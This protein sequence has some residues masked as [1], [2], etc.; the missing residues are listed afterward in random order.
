MFEQ[1]VGQTCP[2]CKK[3]FQVLADETGSHPCPKCG[4]HPADYEVIHEADYEADYEE[5]VLPHDSND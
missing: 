2:K 1:P 5:G 3:R 4:Y